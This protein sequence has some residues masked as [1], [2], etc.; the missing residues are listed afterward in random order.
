MARA[1]TFVDVN[2]VRVFVWTWGCQLL[3]QHFYA[4]LGLSNLFG[5]PASRAQPRSGLRSLR[6]EADRE[7]GGAEQDMGRPIWVDASPLL[8]SP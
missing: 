3:A 5:A 4:T 7:G 2:S 8:C 6:G 1:P